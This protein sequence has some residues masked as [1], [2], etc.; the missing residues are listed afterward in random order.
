LYQEIEVMSL[1]KNATSILSVFVVAIMLTATVPVS[2]GTDRSDQTFEPRPVSGPALKDQY[3]FQRSFDYSPIHLTVNPLLGAKE[4]S[5]SGLQKTGEPGTPSLPVE[6][7]TL[8]LPPGMKV[9]SVLAQDD[10]PT[11]IKIDSKITPIPEVFQTCG[12]TDLTDKDLYVFGQ[13]YAQEGLFPTTTASYSESFGLTD[14]A[15]LDQT[16]DNIV[17]SS[18]VRSYFVD[19]E[20]F[21]VQYDPT[22]DIL[23]VHKQLDLTVTYGPDPSF[24]HPLTNYRAPSYD[25]VIITSRAFVPTF[26]VLS[27]HHNATG[28][29][30]TVVAVEDI[31]SGK[32][33]AASATGVDNAEKIKIFIKNATDA[34]GLTYVTLGGDSGIIPSRHAWVAWD[35]ATDMYYSDISLSDNSFASWDTNHDGKWGNWT[36]D[37]NKMDLRPDVHLGR[38]P[39]ATLAQAAGMVSKVR[40]Y[41]NT[42]AGEKFFKNVTFL[43]GPNAGDGTGYADWLADNVYPASEGW[44]HNKLY[45]SMSTVTNFSKPQNSSVGFM[46]FWGHGGTDSWLGGS[47]FT[48]A[49]INA[50]SNFDALPIVS[51]MACDCG[52]FDGPSDGFAETFLKNTGGGALGVLAGT[53]T[54][55]ADDMNTW[56]G[57][58]NKYFHEAN[59]EHKIKRLGAMHSAGINLF[60]DN[61]NWKGSSLDYKNLVEYV[62]FGDPAATIGGI[63]TTHAKLSTD[64]AT[65]SALP[66]QNVTFNVF[67]EDT[68]TGWADVDLSFTQTIP[69]RW[70][71][72]LPYNFT[73]VVAHENRTILINVTVP[74][75][76]L[77]GERLVMTLRANSTNF[78][79]APLDLHLTVLAKTN[80]SFSID[81]AQTR[82]VVEA[83][84][85]AQYQFN[86]H[87][88]GNG[89]FPFKVEPTDAP[90]DWNLSSLLSEPYIGPGNTYAM[91]WNVTPGPTAL[92]KTYPITFKASII[93][94]PSDLKYVW[95][96]TT[97]K[98][99]VGFDIMPNRTVA[100]VTG[101]STKFNIS[102]QSHGNDRADLV[103]SVPNKP[104]GTGWAVSANQSTLSLEPYANSSFGVEVIV[105]FDAL[106]GNYTVTLG[107]L[108]GTPKYYK[109][110]NLTIIIPARYDFDLSMPTYEGIITP[111]T[112][113]SIIV[114]VAN[115]GNLD[116]T[117][118]IKVLGMPTDWTA[119]HPDQITVYSRGVQTVTIDVSM[120]TDKVLVGTYNL[121]ITLT[122]NLSGL[123]K[124]IVYSAIV[125]RTY[126]LKASLDITEISADPGQTISFLVHVSNLGNGPD[127]FA[128]SFSQSEKVLAIPPV[129]NLSLAAFE[130]GTVTVLATPSIT[131]E[132]DTIT[133]SVTVNSLEKPTLAQSV[134]LTMKVNRTFGLDVVYVGAGTTITIYSGSKVQ[135]DFVLKNLGNDRDNIAISMNRPKGISMDNSVPVRVDPFSNRSKSLEVMVGSKVKAGTVTLKISFMSQGN[136]SKIIAIKLEVKNHKV[137]V[138]G[139]F[140]YLVAAVVA[141]IVVFIVVLALL[142]R[143]K[144]KKPTTTEKKQP[145]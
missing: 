34:W 17:L 74:Q 8:A 86:L 28:I 67:L 96:N 47:S 37:R 18:S 69:Q 94:Q 30:T 15:G 19:I 91:K 35:F 41:D 99:T 22:E 87:N 129:N 54:S 141:I 80:Y 107:V 3:L 63:S 7:V 98:Q 27:D 143:S 111:A 55:N 136:F 133:V 29:I 100:T 56:A 59:K 13:A 24:Q 10:A 134:K 88:L 92:N 139:M 110:V 104:S 125:E 68:G 93:S 48:T 60:L 46:A 25:N 2:A 142:M 43:V 123:S 95:T 102:V 103:I 16:R 105:P 61:K 11:T 4:L 90:A 57:A 108:R 21:P 5:L 33:F 40:N 137:P 76:A 145:E 51:I 75:D 83:E 124:A 62:L 53:Q 14:T 126:D 42:S 72:S 128:F 138:Q 82:K 66:G 106:A 39:A 44:Y 131:A 64:N 52:N 89:E 101:S 132:P 23:L 73:N 127:R 97:V 120:A 45:N 122:S 1:L 78:P 77:A 113:L 65:L 140:A 32:Y 114:D 84:H 9:I 118:D 121:S 12:V 79:E 116:D 144:G 31:Y 117:Y 115:N 20:L 81:C 58:T 119:A 36:D 26:Q 38:L 70:S 6:H 130:N 50:L 49:D 85:T 135:L 112:A 109:E 71:V